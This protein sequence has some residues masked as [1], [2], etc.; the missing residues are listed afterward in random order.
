MMIQQN[1]W[2][3]KMQRKLYF[4]RIDRRRDRQEFIDRILHD[5]Y[6]TVIL[7]FAAVFSGGFEIWQRLYV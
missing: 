4:V 5:C 6:L 2:H 3:L 1:V 7:R